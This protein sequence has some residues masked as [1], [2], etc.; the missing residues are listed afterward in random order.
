M[1]PGPIRQVQRAVDE[2]V[3]SG[4]EQCVQ[5]AAYLHGEQIAEGPSTAERIAAI[6]AAA[7]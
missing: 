2:A 6:V 3:G 1:S 5:V 4:K 7:V